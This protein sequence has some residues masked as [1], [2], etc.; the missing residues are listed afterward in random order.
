MEPGTG[1]TVPLNR[2]PGSAHGGPGRRFLFVAFHTASAP[3]EASSAWRGPWSM[4]S[5]EALCSRGSTTASPAAAPVEIRP[6]GDGARQECSAVLSRTSR[7]WRDVETVR[8]GEPDQMCLGRFREDDA[9][10]AGR[11]PFPLSCRRIPRNSEY[12]S[13]ASSRSLH[14]RIVFRSTLR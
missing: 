12:L 8:G 11:R 13:E 3:W 1:G 9:R 10:F 2:P 6:E 7:S 4:A 5:R 14:A